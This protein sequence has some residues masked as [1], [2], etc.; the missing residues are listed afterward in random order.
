LCFLN[1]PNTFELNVFVAFQKQSESILSPILA[2]LGRM[3]NPLW[4]NT[5]STGVDVAGE[6]K[7]FSSSL[8]MMANS[9]SSGTAFH[10]LSAE[11]SECRRTNSKYNLTVS[12][13]VTWSEL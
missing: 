9:F 6:Q 1:A 13:T 3:N 10:L 8:C 5:R 11:E 4:L 2:L 12:D 7:T